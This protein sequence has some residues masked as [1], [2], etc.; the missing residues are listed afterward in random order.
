MGSKFSFI[1]LF[2]FFVF[3]AFSS[4]IP[5]ICLDNFSQESS[6][7]NLYVINKIEKEN[8]IVDN[9][10]V[11]IELL[12]E[13]VNS[14]KNI[15]YYFFIEFNNDKIYLS[16]YNK[17]KLIE[18]VVLNNNNLDF[19]IIK[20]FINDNLI[21]ANESKNNVKIKN[22]SISKNYYRDFPY[23]SVSLTGVTYRINYD[24]RP[25]VFSFFPIIFYI[26]YFVIK[27]LEIGV[28]FRF[29]YN[30]NLIKY[31]DVNSKNFYSRNIYLD[32]EYGISIGYSLFYEK[33][34]YSIGV[35]FFNKSIFFNENEYTKNFL[36]NFSIYQKINLKI[37]KI[38]YYTIMVT[39][40][41]TQTY[42]KIK[43]IETYM[44]NYGLPVVEISLIGISLIFWLIKIAKSIII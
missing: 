29:S 11:K 9:N 35:L 2:L 7:V 12:K 5:I 26:D 1:L 24:E 40:K 17:I 25:N 13:N 10:L 33:T 31:Y 16:F 28:N 6:L 44:F 3:F 32:M 4:I 41:T 22:D 21:F 19:E 42:Y 23:L 30:T 14:Y 39:F 8:F 43:H 20:K 18:M 38:F 15:N 37:S 27:N 34:H 36:P